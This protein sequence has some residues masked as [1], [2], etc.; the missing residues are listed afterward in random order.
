MATGVLVPARAYG[1]RK[2]PYATCWGAPV[3]G[4]A[5]GGRPQIARR[6]TR[7]RHGGVQVLEANKGHFLLAMAGDQVPVL[8]CHLVEAGVMAE[9]SYPCVSGS[10]FLSI[11]DMI[12]S[13]G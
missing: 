13:Y 7:G 2:A 9:R 12:L 10:V 5:G 1:C 4:A 3:P 8:N 11:T 6:N